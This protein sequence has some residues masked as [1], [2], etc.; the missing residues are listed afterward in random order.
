MIDKAKSH[1]DAVAK[2]RKLY[3]EVCK[4]SRE[5]LKSAFT[6][7]DSFQPP[8]T[9]LAIP[10]RSTP[11]KIHYSFD[12]AQQVCLYST[13]HIAH[14]AE[15]PR[16]RRDAPMSAITF[17]AHLIAESFAV[18]VSPLNPVLYTLYENLFCTL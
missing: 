16:H 2:E 13:I 9:N 1:L 3:R 17:N 11:A 6:I 10:P 5:E 12:M 8:A 7:N 14:M 15:V 4:A 18:Y